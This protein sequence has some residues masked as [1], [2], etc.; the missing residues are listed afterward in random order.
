MEILMA[1]SRPWNSLV[2]SWADETRQWGIGLSL[3][4]VEAFHQYLELLMNANRSINLIG[5]DQPREVLVQLFRDALCLLKT[6]AWPVDGRLLDLGSGAGIPG[7][8]LKIIDPSLN[9]WLLEARAKKALFLRNAVKQLGFSGVD[10]LAGRAETLAHDPAYRGRAA[11]VVSRSVAALP[12]LV[13]LGLPFLEPGGRMFAWKGSR[14]GDE[15][16]AA[17]SAIMRLGGSF[18]EAITL[19]VPGCEYPRV[20]VSIRKHSPTPQNF[21]RR[22]GVPHRKPL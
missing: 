12:E 2:N 7:V 10:I 9:L 22:N 8:P 16:A 5:I 18:E 1:D 14:W 13:E 20:L 4:M 21:P 6:T 15:L 19:S 3:P 11:V 17:D